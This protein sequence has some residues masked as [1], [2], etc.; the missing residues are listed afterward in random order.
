[1]KIPRSWSR[2]GR[3]SGRSGGTFFTSGFLSTGEG[4]Q[5]LCA[6]LCL[7][8]EGATVKNSTWGGL[9]RRRAGRRRLLWSLQTQSSAFFVNGKRFSFFSSF[10]TSQQM[11]GSHLLLH[12]K[13]LHKVVGEDALPPADLT[14]PPAGVRTLLQ[15]QH[16]NGDWNSGRRHATTG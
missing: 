4:S 16:G 10:K 12:F 14:H 7:G 3:C 8:R 13:E 15:T 11:R 1:M 6:L 5:C 9:G 2:C